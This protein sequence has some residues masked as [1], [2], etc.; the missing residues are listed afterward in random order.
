[1]NGRNPHHNS[2]LHWQTLWRKAR[3]KKITG[4][5]TIAAWYSATRPRTL[6]ATYAPMGVAAAVAIQDKVFKSVPF[7]L[8]LVGALFLQI[9][10]NLINEYFDYT[11]G[12]DSLK[13]AGQG[14]TI[15][16][17]ILSPRAVLSGAVITVLA[18]VVIGLYLL[19]QSGPLLLWIGIGG[20]L[21]VIT[22]TAGPFPLAYN[23][24]GE[25]AVGIFMGPVFIIGAYYVMDT[26]VYWQ[27]ALISLP[28]AF[29]VAAILHA[30]NIRDMEADR[31][32]NKHTL[33]VMF[34]LGFSRA[35]Y[36]FLV[37]G[38]YIVLVALVIA[39]QMPALTLL[40]LLTAREGMALIRIVYTRT[41]TPSLHQAQGRTARLHGQFGLMMVA[42][43]LIWL[44]LQ[45][46]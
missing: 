11:R 38:A 13:E 35:E 20:V 7:V 27:L 1:V 36:A 45:A 34:G 5:P 42:G 31:A 9:A 46:I 29:M 24:L 41:D 44:A 21:V 25:I 4:N 30:N 15:K 10:A 43:W 17:Q 37:G 19:S 14:M 22:Y 28:I 33:A 26:H 12:A 8:A 3:L 18:G 16:K 39:G 32:V 40:A 6:T 2:D 23:G